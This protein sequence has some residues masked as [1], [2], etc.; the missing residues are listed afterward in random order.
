MA[1][2]QGFKM[3]FNTGVKPYNRLNLAGVNKGKF[4]LGEHEE[5]KDGSIHIA[6]YLERQPDKNL[7]LDYLVP[8]GSLK[9]FGIHEYQTTI[10]IIAGG[11]LS[12]YAVFTK[13]NGV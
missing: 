5:L 12:D 1:E 10:K 4:V 3:L 6:Y 11:M 13:L 9:E 7:R 8:E 2:Q